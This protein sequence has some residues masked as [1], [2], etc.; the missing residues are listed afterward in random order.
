MVEGIRHHPVVSFDPPLKEMDYDN[1]KTFLGSVHYED[2]LLLT[3]RGLT[4]MGLIQN[5][6]NFESTH[7]EMSMDLSIDY[8]SP[9]TSHATSDFA[10]YFL[11]H[12]PDAFYQKDYAVFG[13]PERLIGELSGFVISVSQND[14][15]KQQTRGK[16]H[17]KGRIVNNKRQEISLKV[18]D[19]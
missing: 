16:S 5:M 18:F 3:P 9:E 17:A 1:W 14:P 7:W 6:W 13:Q 8:Q 15:N 12:N 4:S 11:R 19:E 2:K 10:L